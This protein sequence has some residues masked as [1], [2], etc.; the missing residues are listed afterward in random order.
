MNI[1]KRIA[2]RSVVL[3][4]MP[5]AL[6]AGFL[7][8]SRAAQ[9]ETT[10]ESKV[11]AR[12]TRAVDDTDRVV[13]RGNVHPAARAE[14][15]EG[16]AADSRPMNRMVLLLQRSAE[17]EKAL[18]QFMEDQQNRNSANYH[19]WLTPE[20]FGQQFGPAD[21][22][23]QAVTDWL[24]AHGFQVKRISKGRTMIEFS[25]NAGLVRS[26]FHTEIHRLLVR[27]KE[28]VAN[29]SDPEIPSALAPVVKGVV[30]LH[31]FRP[32]S[33]LHNVGTFQRNA[34]TGEIRP[35][36]TFSDVNGQFFGV[37]PADFA[38][39]YN[40]QTT[41]ATGAGQ[42]IA[43][44]GQSNINLQDVAD[45][46]SIFGL[47]GNVPQVILNGPDPGL[48]SG[49]E[50]E[51]DLDVEWAGA[52]AQQANII[53]V[54][55]QTAQ[56]DG[57]AGIDASAMYIVDNNVAP[58][59]SESY[60]SCEAG[61]G[62]AGNAFYNAMWQQAAA[63]GIT[64]VISAGDNGSA[65]C[66]PA[67][68]PAN[69][70]AASLG[71][72]ISGF[73]STPFNLAMGGTDFDDATNQGTFWSTTNTS[74]TPPV[75]ASAKGYIQESTWNDTCART[76][77]AGNIGGLCTTV[78]GSGTDLAA[79]SGGSSSIYT[80]VLKPSWQAGLGDANRD[81]PDVS[82]FSSDGQNKSFYIV[83]ESD[84]DI[85]GD[86]GCNLTKF[87]N[88]APFHDFQAI[89]GTSAATPTFAA[90]IALINQ[91]KGPRQGNAAY[92]LYNTYNIAKATP[93][94]ICNSSSFTSPSPSNTCVFYD[95][96]KGNVSVACVGG[97][98]NCSN[99]S[100][101]AN[102]FGL[103]ATARGGTT[104]AYMAGSGYD[105][106]TGLG[107]VNVG[108]LITAWTAPSATV[109]TVTLNTLPASI[110][111]GQTVTVSGTV[112]PSTSTGVV[113]LENAA[114]GVIV[115][116]DAG[117]NT[118]VSA[119][120]YNFTTSLLPAGSY[121]VL[122]HYGA[123][124]TLGTGDSGAQTVNITKAN[125]QVVVSFVTFSSTGVPS[126]S[127]ATQTVTYGSNYILRVDVENASNGKMCENLSSTTFFPTINFVCPTGTIQL[128]DGGGPLK[129]FPNAQTPNA[130]NVSKLN[131]RGFAEDQPIQLPVGTHSITAMYTP[132]TNSSY[133]PPAGPSNTLSVTITKASTTTVVTPTPASIPAGGNVTL[134]AT[135]STSSNGEPP[136]GA[137]VTN[138][139]TVQFMNGGAA[140]S[141]TVS[142]SGTSGGAS[143]TG[144]ASCTATLA[145]TLS[146]IEPVD[147]P[148]TPPMLPLWML[149]AAWILAILLIVAQHASPLQR[150]WPRLGW[151]ASRRFAY[152]ALGLALLASLSAGMA[153][154]SGASGGGGHTDSIT[155]VY[156]GDA[157]Y[158]GSTSPATAV[159]VQ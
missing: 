5:L 85:A 58:V 133:N 66:D 124:G 88:N 60:G 23:I 16:V 92:A 33:F 31:N 118:G 114:T 142:Y 158:S 108:N 81:I 18:A 71:L 20:Q 110:T 40:V 47:P 125:S 80:G 50:S 42:S 143:S 25:G 65:G 126:L 146:Q 152:A 122:A 1:H 10:Q 48:V 120:S 131:D 39:I 90:I 15:D 101:A 86:T 97:S 19:T 153:G 117:T 136:C 11:A 62:T 112:A 78:S 82:L 26:A 134:S 70:N 121:S 8:K 57:V 75:P 157:N 64:V 52:V 4:V 44:V 79:G 34:K 63:E 9:S 128:L 45:F 53:F 41:T 111:V 43:I 145:T 119:G 35:A 99:P 130:T 68:P 96:T 84:M 155:A 129:D 49:D 46:R 100:S 151:A 74:T 2:R 7:A 91:V 77:T 141:G 73:A 32:R 149:V 22:D 159:T 156:S 27:G 94:Q 105:L 55:T 30:G 95:I 3:M 69:Q 38:T 89:G 123:G 137:G 104:P 98:P 106:A 93:G 59:L 28:H 154:C 139:G 127:T 83:C 113:A 138:P 72:G 147:G 103:M 150:R 135:V 115:P 36:F 17:Q 6:A 24:G 14:F 12:V 76:A 109:F 107:S 132:D 29:M 148:R 61:L 67:A 51:S 140:I 21:A 102:Q 13:L 87:S 56:T 144:Q 37:G 116:A 54:T